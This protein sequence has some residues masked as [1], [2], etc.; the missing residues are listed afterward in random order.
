[1]A[2]VYRRGSVWYLRWRD[3]LGRPKRRA[4]TARSAADARALLAEVVGQ[5]QRQRLNLEAAPLES[6]LTLEQL[7]RWWLAERCS[8]SARAHEG[9]RLGKHVFA[10]ALAKLPLQL[11][12]T[13]LFEE[14]LNAIERD[15]AAAATVN[16]VRS[17]LHTVFECAR[18]PPRKW[19]G[20]N[21]LAETRVREVTRKQ[22]PTLT[23]EQIRRVLAVVGPDWLGVMAVAA[24]LGLRKGEIFALRRSDYDAELQT[25]QVAGSHQQ[26]TTKGKRIDVLP[27]PWVLRPY[28]DA[29]VKAAKTSPWLFPKRD[30][31]QRT[32]EAD[33]HLVLR[34]A[35]ARAGIVLRWEQTCR[36]CKG[37][38][39]A[40]GRPPPP[41][42]VTGPAADGSAPEGRC[43]TCDQKLWA[44]GVPTAIRFHDLRHSVATNLLRAGVPLSHVQKILRH[45]SIS[46]TVGTYGHLDVS[47]LRSS[48]E[49]VSGAATDANGTPDTA[50]SVQIGHKMGSNR[51]GGRDA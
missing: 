8:E 1:M 24:Y 19:Q 18:Q 30:G 27:V 49:A 4:T 37:L 34:R 20:A 39:I 31:H 45:A 10:H 17:T 46:T 32:R 25:L 21:P 26:T 11:V 36:R 48:I 3:A 35:A 23:P 44:H 22:Y 15:G 2:N 5:V 14:R 42:V 50:G 47:E 12:T 6:R 28:L 9:L 38:A 40:E 51:S 33:P 43:P 13:D 29:A 16:R 41:V 7:C